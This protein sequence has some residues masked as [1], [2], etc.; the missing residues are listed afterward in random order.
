MK[1]PLIITIAT[2]ILIVTLMSA[3][4]LIV[5]KD[6]LFQPSNSNISY[7]TLVNIGIEGIQISNET[8]G[9]DANHWELINYTIVSNQ[10]INITLVHVLYPYN[11][12]E[13]SGLESFPSST[14]K[15]H[16]N[17]AYTEYETKTTTPDEGSPGSG[18]APPPSAQNLTDEPLPNPLRFVSIT[19]KAVDFVTEDTGKRYRMDILIAII[20]VFL[21]LIIIIGTRKRNR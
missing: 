6:V 16:I 7:H 2:L 10:S 13:I 4:A 3:S 15:Q 20:I 9:Y 18:S 14:S 11:I 17:F 21:V 8:F 5:D 1:K 12:E 19:G